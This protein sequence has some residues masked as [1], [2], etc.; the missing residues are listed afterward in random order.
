VVFVVMPDV[1]LFQLLCDCF[2]VSS[3]SASALNDHNMPSL[4]SLLYTTTLL[5]LLLL[6]NII[7]FTGFQCPFSALT[8]LVGRQEGHP[9]C[10]N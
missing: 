1:A 6:L 7:L 10:K 4:L 2:A 3:I 5:I 9:A 8:L